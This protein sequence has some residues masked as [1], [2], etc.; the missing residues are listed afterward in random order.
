MKII[1]VGWYGTETIGDRAILDGILQIYGKIT[2][3]LICSIASLYPMFTERTLI[4]DESI[5]QTNINVCNFN[6]F[7]IKDFQIL[8]SEITDTD[9][10]IMGGGPLMDLYELTYIK[11]AFKYAK[12][13]NKKT[14]LFGCGLGPLNKKTYQKIVNDIFELSDLIIFRDNASEQYSYELYG[15]KYKNKIYT[16]CDPA[17]FSIIKYRLKH[18]IER[19]QSQ[20]SINFRDITSE[21]H[22]K[23]HIE[24]F[25]KIISWASLNYEK[26]NLVPMHTFCIGGDDRD[27]FSSLIINNDYKNL[28]PLY[29]PLDL[30]ETYKI[31]SESTACIG[32]RYHS[33]V[34]QTLLNGNNFILDYT[35]KKT[36]KISGFLDEIDSEHFYS[37]RVLNITENYPENIYTRLDYLKDNAVFKISDNVFDKY[38][39]SYKRLLTS[40]LEN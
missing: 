7:D 33:I 27:V 35:K 36:G 18:K 3:H 23:N 30:Y 1:V 14:I 24:L 20:I 40:E 25:E 11:K 32:M 13:L 17:I 19:N 28:S 6:V 5:Y 26:V 12:K 9:H 34:M 38:I 4:M 15:E 2:N 10:I 29:K 8:R 31:F 37:N 16:I 39:D 21:Y 22:K